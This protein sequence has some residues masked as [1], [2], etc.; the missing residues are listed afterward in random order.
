M[1]FMKNYSQL[2]TAERGRISLPQGRTII[3][4]QFGGPKNIYIQAIN[5][6][7]R[8]Y[9]YVYTYVTIKIK[10]KEDMNLKVGGLE[11]G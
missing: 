5:G 9:L 11:R 10:E 7:S 1:Q 6:L 2:I 8:L 4:Y 3:G